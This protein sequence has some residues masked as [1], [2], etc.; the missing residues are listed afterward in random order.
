MRCVCRGAAITSLRES[1]WTRGRPDE[2]E[3]CQNMSERFFQRACRM[4]REWLLKSC[5]GVGLGHVMCSPP[6]SPARRVERRIC[7]S[8]DVIHQ[9]AEGRSPIAG[10]SN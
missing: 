5:Q 3:L 9:I 1:Q 2:R 4:L 6:R 10:V 8:R 7:A